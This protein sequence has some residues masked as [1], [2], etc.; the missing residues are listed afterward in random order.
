MEDADAAFTPVTVRGV[1]LD[2]ETMLLGPRSPPKHSAPFDDERGERSGYHL[3]TP[4]LLVPA[5]RAEGTAAAG[6]QDTFFLQ[7]KKVG[8]PTARVYAKAS[9][10]F[11]AWAA[12]KR[13]KLADQ[14]HRDLAMSAYLHS[15]YF[16]GEGIFAARAALYGHAHC[17]VLNLRDQKEMALS[18][19][20]LAG[21]RAV[22]PDQQR[23]PC[24]WEALLLI[25][26]ELLS[27]DDPV[28]LEA[29]RASV[30]SFEAYT[31]PSE[32]LGVCSR[33]VILVSSPTVLKYPA[34]SLR[35]APF[36]AELHGAAR[37]TK[38]GEYD[39][40]VVLGDAVS[41]AAGRGWIAMLAANLA[42]ARAPEQALLALTLAQ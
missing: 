20:A 7:H 32:L 3:I 40:T 31:R 9:E 16:N 27:H 41:Q 22:A 18:R 21:Y 42:R 13:H 30:I 6:E 14:H 26:E 5:V 8:A 4:L 25:A 29:A 37:T 38:A 34:V 15:L 10:E 24:P 2:G 39:D 19:K 11:L 17:Q 12:Q 36:V 35:I 33:D 23:D 28:S 1:L